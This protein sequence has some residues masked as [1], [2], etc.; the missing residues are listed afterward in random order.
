MRLENFLILCQIVL[1]FSCCKVFTAVVINTCCE[2][3]QAY[4]TVKDKCVPQHAVVEGVSK[5]R[6]DSP[7]LSFI[8][9]PTAFVKILDGRN[10]TDDVEFR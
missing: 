7:A 3:G 6:N 2:H 5:A 4:D 10:D 9:L 1:I 8:T